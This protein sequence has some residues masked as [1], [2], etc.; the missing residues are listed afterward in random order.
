MPYA[1]LRLYFENPVCHLLE[2]PVEQ[3]IV[4]EY[5]PGLRKLHE[6]QVF[7]THAGQLLSR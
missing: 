4:V 5:R 6:L 1:T 2:Q 7:L 3:Y